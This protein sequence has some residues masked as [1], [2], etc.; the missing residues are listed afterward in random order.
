MAAVGRIISAIARACD[1]AAT[2]VLVALVVVYK[3][4]LSPLLGRHCRF[5]P[6][7]STYFRLAVEKH[8]A[9]RGG[10]KGPWLSCSRFPKCRG[11]GKW[12][13]IEESQR[14]ALE[15]ALKNHELK[16]PVAVVK[17]M[18]GR[19]LTD[20][21]GKPLPSAPVVGASMDDQMASEGSLE[22]VADEL[23]M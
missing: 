14:H 15:L 17:T 1:R 5:E 16:H 9:L 2:A 18:S 12:N 13:E 20:S 11:R 7:C 3:C 10:L 6:T 22:A 21:R 19:A 23:G 4:T 8:G